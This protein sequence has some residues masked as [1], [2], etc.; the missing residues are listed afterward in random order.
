MIKYVIRWDLKM[1]HNFQTLK[2]YLALVKG[3]ILWDFTCP[4]HGLTCSIFYKIT[5]HLS[6]FAIGHSCN[7]NCARY[8]VY[9]H[10]LF[11][12]ARRKN[13]ISEL[14]SELTVIVRVP[15]SLSK[16]QIISTIQICERY[17]KQLVFIKI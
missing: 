13:L 17:V 7:V 6:L 8:K 16:M 12:I 9:A 2:N 3:Q 10:L 4:Y 14:R 11:L 5:F 1:S 15:Y